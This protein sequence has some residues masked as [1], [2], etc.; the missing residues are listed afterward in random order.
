MKNM[1]VNLA[2]SAKVMC[3]VC[4][5]VSTRLKK[6]ETWLDVLYP[7]PIY[8]GNRITKSNGIFTSRPNPKLIADFLIIFYA[9]GRMI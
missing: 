4:G 2:T 5:E 8:Y 6:V 3:G 7:N 1:F 9:L